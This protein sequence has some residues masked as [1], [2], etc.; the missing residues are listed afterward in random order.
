MVKQR[1]KGNG[2]KKELEKSDI[3]AIYHLMDTGADAK[4]IAK[5][6]DIGIK[7]I[8]DIISN[9]PEP[10]NTAIKTTSAKTNSKDLMIRETSGK[11][12]KSVSIMTKEASQVHDSFRQNLGNTSSRT[13]KNAIYRPNK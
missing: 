2:M 10:Q 3:Y 13:S 6:L 11:R 8:K 4:T 12:N 9:R 1:R 5:E 7:L